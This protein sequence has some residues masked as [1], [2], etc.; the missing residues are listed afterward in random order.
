[1]IISAYS[2]YDCEGIKYFISEDEHFWGYDDLIKEEYDI[3]VV[4]EWECRRL[5]S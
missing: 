3:D 1:M 5:I 2:D 4:K